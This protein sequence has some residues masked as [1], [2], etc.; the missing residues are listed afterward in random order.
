MAYG[1]LLTTCS[2]L[3]KADKAQLIQRR[4][5]LIGCRVLLI[6]CRALSWMSHVTNE[7]VVSQVMYVH[8]PC[9]IW[10]IYVINKWVMSHVNEL[11]HI[12]M[13]DVTY[14][15]G[16]AHMDAALS[17]KSWLTRQWV[18]AHRETELW[19]THEHVGAQVSRS[20]VTHVSHTN[21]SWHTYERVGSKVWRSSLSPVSR[22]W[23]CFWGA[24]LWISVIQCVAVC[25][26]AM[27]FVAVCCNLL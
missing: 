7:S 15:W 25:C 19:H 3:L 23:S 1:A 17:L 4:P 12:R 10:M 14:K 21:D 27:Q 11:C 18:M 6:G 22:I 26:S 20:H 5:P 2:A 13:S 16:T 24:L 8:E 9:H